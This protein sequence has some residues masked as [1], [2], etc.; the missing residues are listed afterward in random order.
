MDNS[1]FDRADL[2]SV[3]SSCARRGDAGSLLSTAKAI[4]EFRMMS[5]DFVTSDE[6]LANALSEAAI[7][8]GCTVVFD[9]RPSADALNSRNGN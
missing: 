4:G 1:R 6:E 5:G 7:A 2:L 3:V 8:L 9:E